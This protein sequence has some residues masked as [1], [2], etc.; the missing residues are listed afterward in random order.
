MS[1][2][3]MR[4]RSSISLI[5]RV[6]RPE[7]G[8]REREDGRKGGSEDDIRGIT[9]MMMELILEAKMRRID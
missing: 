6:I 4:L 5:L 3:R 1:S 7:P 2:R 9:M 8:I